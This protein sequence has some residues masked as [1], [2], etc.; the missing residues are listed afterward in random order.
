MYKR[1][2]QLRLKLTPLEYYVTQGKGYERPF[3]GMNWW[4]KDV[5]MYSCKICSQKLFM[6]DHKFDNKSGYPTFWYH[7][8]DAINYL[9]GDIIRPTYSN[10]HED[11]VLKNKIPTKR[12]VCTNCDSHLGHLFDDG[13][14]PFNT[15]LQI[16]NEA[17]VFQPKPWF[18]MPILSN[19]EERKIREA[20]KITIKE[21]QPFFDLQDDE[22]KYGF[23]TWDERDA[24]DR[25]E[26]NIAD[27]LEKHRVQKGKWN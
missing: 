17:I 27:K 15:R 11:P 9:G 20:R 19:I 10:A 6:S 14:L 2:V 12:V 21:Q 24:K 1:N 23:K 13:P 22:K 8:K 3:T 26:R 7:I 5:G 25:V 18:K 16:S 4:T